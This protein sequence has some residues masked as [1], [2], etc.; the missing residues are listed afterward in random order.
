[1]LPLLFCFSWK[2]VVIPSERNRWKKGEDGRI[3]EEEEA[4]TWIRGGN[5]KK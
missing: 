1:M 4:K 3:G 2:F 5:G